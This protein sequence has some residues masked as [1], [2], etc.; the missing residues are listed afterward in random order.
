MFLLGQSLIPGRVTE[1]RYTSCNCY[2]FP[3][4]LDSKQLGEA[5]VINLRI[6]V[7][8]VGRFQTEPACTWNL[9]ST[10]LRRTCAAR[11][12]IP[13]HIQYRNVH[14]RSGIARMTNSAMVEVN[15]Q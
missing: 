14:D 11:A 7:A 2:I 12:D 15:A 9:F 4:F 5:N 3:T 8:Q 6:A 1:D 10:K 13:K